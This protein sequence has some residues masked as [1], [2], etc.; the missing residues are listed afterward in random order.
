MNASSATDELVYGVVGFNNGDTDLTPGS[1]QTEYWDQTVNSSIA[2]AGSTKT[3]AA[4]VAMSWTSTSATWTIGAVSIKPSVACDLKSLT[5]NIYSG[6]AIEATRTGTTGTASL[7]NQANVP[8]ATS[9]NFASM[10]ASFL[11][12]GSSSSFVSVK[13]GGVIFPIG[14]TVGAVG[15]VTGGG[16][17]RIRTYLSGTPQE[18]IS[19]LSNTTYYVGHEN[20][21]FTATKTFDE[22]Q[23]YIN[24]S[25]LLFGSISAD[26]YSMFVKYPAI[27][28]SS[29]NTNPTTVGGTN[30]A[31]NLT[32]AGGLS[33]YTY[34]WSNSATT[35]DLASIN[36]G[37]YTVTITDANTCTATYSTTLFDQLTPGGVTGAAI[38]LKADAGVTTGATM[39][40]AD[41]SGNNRNGTQAT[42]TNQPT[43]NSSLINFNPALVL[44]G[45]NDYLTLSNLTGLP[46]GT[47]QVEAFGVARNLNTGGSWNHIIAYGSAAGN[48]FFTLGKQTGTANAVTGFNG[49]DAISTSLEYTG[50]AT[51]LCDGKYT[52]TIGV[53][54]TFGKQ[55]GTVT[56]TG[57]KATT[58][59]KIGVDP[60]TALTTCWNGNIAETILFPTNLTATQVNQV[61]SYLAIKYGVT[62]DQTTAQNYI[63]SDGTT[64]YWSGTTNS[65]HNDN[66]AGIA[67][68]DASALNQK[69]SKSQNTGLQVVI[70][71]GNTIST[72]NILNTNSFSADKSA[73][74][75]GDDAGSVAAWTS[76]GA[77]SNIRQILARSWKVQE[78][79]TVGS[80]KVQIA[81]NASSGLPAEVT[82]VYLLVDDDG[83]FTSGATEVAM[84]LN[85]SDWEANVDFTSGQF[86]TFATQVT[87][88]PGGVATSITLWLKADATSTI[89]GNTNG[90]SVTAWNSSGN[91]TINTTG[92]GTRPIYRTNNGSFNYNPSL[93]FTGNIQEWLR[94]TTTASIGANNGSFLAVSKNTSGPNFHTGDGGTKT[95]SHGNTGYGYGGL[96][97]LTNY[98][99]S[100]ANIVGT[101]ATRSASS[102]A[103][104]NGLSVTYTAGATSPQASTQIGG[105]F[106]NGINE[107]GL[108]GEFAEVVSFSSTLS[109]ADV[110][111]ISSYLGI[112]YGITLGTTAS[113]VNYTASDGTTVYWTGSATYQNNVAGIVRDD[114]SALN[115]KQSK[116]INTGLQVVMGNGNT[117]AT[118]NASNSNTFSADKS[119]LLWGDNAGS[120]A[121]WTTTGAPSARQ[122]VARTWKVQETGTVGSVK[123]QV[124]DNTASGLPVE[125]TAV[126]LLVDADGNF[127]AGA[128]EVT[129]TLN[130]SNWEA[131]VDFTSGQFFTFA[132]QVPPAPGG[133]VTNLNM[134]F[135]AD[136]DAMV[137]QWN[138]QISGYHQTQATATQQPVL[139]TNAVNFNPAFTFD[140][141]NDFFSNTVL[142]VQPNA[143]DY[144]TVI[145]PNTLAGDHDMLGFGNAGN[146]DAAKEFRM[147]ANKLQIG[148]ANSGFASITSSSTTNS[149]WQIA[150]FNRLSGAAKLN[151][152]GLQVATATI[153]TAP[154]NINQLNIGS[155]RYFGVNDLFFNG[156][157]PEV[158]IYTTPLTAAERLKVHSYLAVKYGVT[159][160]QTATQNYVASDGTVLWNGT[161]NSGYKNNITGIA[162]DDASA[163]NQ[164]QSKSVNTG[165][166]VV[167]GNG[168]TIATTN[169]LNTNTFS[170]DKSALVWGDDAGS[171]AS[172]TATGA[173][174]SRQIVARKWKTQETGTVGYVKVQV[175]DNGGTNGLPA[176]TNTVYLLVDADGNFASGATEVAMT[177]NGT[178]WE[179]PVDFTNGQFFTFATQENSPVNLNLAMTAD[180]TTVSSGQNV[181]YTLT[182]TNSGTN[183][184][185]NVQ[186]KDKLPAGVNFVSATPSSGTYN[187][188]TGIWTL[189]SVAG[190]AAPTLTI[191]VTA[192]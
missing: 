50:G 27:S 8:D 141:I 192:Q 55:R 10:S 91:A 26:L 75:W 161:T 39:T 85:G 182:L 160:D 93:V 79:G 32:V 45:T 18:D 109:D 1:G 190:A 119:A 73:L 149:L 188:T 167:M 70:G 151:Y 173:P 191:V 157:I 82:T 176:E 41:Q 4:S 22:I 148:I 36:A 56:F 122:I 15:D 165:L 137:A 139:T 6:A 144:Y 77:P 98:T 114:A 152:N 86:F 19:A 23:F 179:A 17:V 120:V 115:Q 121:A 170:A 118:D 123:V 129:M 44:D 54:S 105:F 24:S 88:A 177:L 69:Q 168:N 100:Q 65:T 83:N 21:S 155:R 2:G 103:W 38:W 127:A 92:T 9:T 43:V 53:I 58:N 134:W 142:P 37:T 95:I 164:K 34:V 84:T 59:G 48:S 57:A 136:K 99:S 117:I 52:G 33:P 156:Q 158:A 171:V 104:G 140:G 163:L 116:S 30:G 166:Q 174:P 96:F 108:V 112:K 113:T 12:I 87:P 172:W 31:I 131:N 133:V 68:D 181:T 51:V 97:T 42:A 135:K 25:G 126:Y 183:T 146:A 102:K 106:N 124:A 78:T 150:N 3:G 47:A 153:S 46:T 107:T 185:T 13:S 138:D 74:V 66:I 125:T 67:R 49:S 29:V 89:T 111:R 11:V 81:D 132:T 90:A 5:T 28:S 159:L 76:T 71:N 62:L 128:T 186:V 101:S 145:N 35:Q 7:T 169:A 14:S 16:T 130:G 60:T 20:R 180:K 80:V 178:N 143:E 94:N 40:W 64:I 162:R 61:N 110:N 72:S 184:A 63:A 187:S 175:P 154:T 147:T 189:P